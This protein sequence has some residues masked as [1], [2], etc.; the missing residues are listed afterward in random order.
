MLVA[1]GGVAVVTLQKEV[2]PAPAQAAAL[3][4]PHTRT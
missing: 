3:T 4:V 1:T 2:G